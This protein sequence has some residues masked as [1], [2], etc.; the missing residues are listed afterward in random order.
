MPD[1]N[2]APKQ[3]ELIPVGTVL[4]VQMMIKPGGQG[5]ESMFKC[6]N[7][8]AEMLECE[9]TVVTP[10]QH[11]KRKFW[12]NFI[13]TGPN[14]GHAKAAE[15]SRRHF[16]AMLESARNFKPNDTSPEATKARSADYGDMQN[17]RFVVKMGIERDKT[18]DYPDKNVIQTVI[19]P[20]S[21]QYVKPEQIPTQQKLPGIVQPAAAKPASAPAAKITRPS[22]SGGRPKED[23]KGPE[24]AE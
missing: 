11:E 15:I 12:Q 20:D 18:G 23:S 3:Q 16:R 8:G 14:D 22:W 24:T 9:F 7:S 6:A 21:K 19:T 13:F 2:D 10:G 4:T 5:P 1:F 17:L